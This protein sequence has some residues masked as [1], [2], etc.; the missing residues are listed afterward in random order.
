MFLFGLKDVAPRFF[1]TQDESLRWL[2]WIHAKADGGN[3]SLHTKRLNRFGCG[4]EKIARRA[5]EFP[6]YCTYTEETAE[7]FRDFP[8][9]ERMRFFEQ[10]ADERVETFSASTTGAPGLLIHVSCTGY[11][12]PSAAQKLVARKQWQ[13]RTAILHA[14]HMG[15]YA[16]LPAVRHAADHVR[17]N[18]TRA[19]IFHSELCTLHLNPRQHSP[20]QLVVQSLFADGHIGYSVDAE[21]PQGRSLEV[22]CV[23]EEIAPDSLDAMTWRVGEHGFQMSLARDVPEIIQGSIGRFLD[24]VCEQAH[25]A[26]S[27]LEGAVFAIHPGGP[28][29]IDLLS[30]VLRARPAQVAHARGVLR[31]RGNMSSATLP[32][33]WQKIL[34]EREISPGQT[35][36]SLAFGPGLTIFGSLMRVRER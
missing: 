2:A 8:V 18:G 34:M 5:Y 17:S 20:E 28:R 14:Y 1:A 6:L 29:I 21:P 10:T 33:I 22:L 7:H 32:H 27:E 31:E 35:V 24:S 9:S 19:D 13:G 11:V 26:R 12:S 16:A 30:D 4:P 3:E 23:R 25:V 15:C 36:L